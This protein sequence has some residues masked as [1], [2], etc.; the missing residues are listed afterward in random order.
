MHASSLPNPP[1]LSQFQYYSK[2]PID[3]NFLHVPSIVTSPSTHHSPTSS[4]DSFSSP[5]SQAISAPV[6]PTNSVPPPPP[7]LL[8]NQP[9]R[10]GNCKFGNKCALSHNQPLKTSTKQINNN[11]NNNGKNING[12]RIN[13]IPEIIR[14]P[15]SQSY[16]N[17]NQQ[18]LNDFSSSNSPGMVPFSRMP[19]SPTEYQNSHRSHS[20]LTASLNPSSAPPLYSD[21]NYSPSSR[22]LRT[23]S[24]TFIGFNNGN[25]NDNNHLSAP[26][27]I[28]FQQRRSL[29]DISQPSPMDPFSTS[30]YQSNVRTK[31]SFLP[32]SSYS[33]SG[34]LS[35][36]SSSFQQLH[37]IPEDRHVHNNNSFN[38]SSYL[39]QNIQSSPLI[40]DVDYEEFIP[41][42]LNDLLTP[43]ERK[44]RR[45]RQ[46]ETLE[47]I[48]PRR[49][50]SNSSSL[51]PSDVQYAYNSHHAVDPSHIHHSTVRS[52][53][54]GFVDGPA[55]SNYSS[56]SITHDDIQPNGFMNFSSPINIPSPHENHSTSTNSSS[57]FSDFR[58]ISRPISINANVTND[59]SII[60]GDSGGV[61]GLKDPV[62]S[63]TTS[64]NN[65]ST[66]SSTTSPT[67][68]SSS[69]SGLAKRN[70]RNSILKDSKH[71]EIKF[72]Q[73]IFVYTHT[74]GQLFR[75]LEY[76]DC[77]FII[78]ISSA[79]N[80]DVTYDTA[81][82]MLF[83]PLFAVLKTESFRC[84]IR[85]GPSVFFILRASRTRSTMSSFC[86]IVVN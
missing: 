38:T 69:N 59:D 32:F 27:N 33:E 85:R 74:I 12:L 65:T 21:D 20:Q 57:L 73:E 3:N 53:P 36:T 77:V 58:V 18:E 25:G 41:S 34:I 1:I 75:L 56:A 35:P 29:P 82:A 44:R 84:M 16:G 48:S 78:D 46:E 51:H 86:K 55:S 60:N 43:D 15:V 6:T 67:T 9:P 76:E 31:G 13:N 19:L 24:P 42:S 47:I 62:N 64:N 5:I 83:H 50:F 2:Q 70:E 52:L 80:N 17:N 28:N 23:T 61:D 22:S 45:S 26:I 63:T 37:S 68:S 11:P 39:D 10:R 7:S 72:K 66:T 4:A 40:D 54:Y 81:S 30:P 79:I 49:L 8:S 71:K 14:S